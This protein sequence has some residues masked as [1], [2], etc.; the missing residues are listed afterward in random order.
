MEKN[1]NKNRDL[2]RIPVDNGSI[3]ISSSKQ[4]GIVLLRSR[5][6]FPLLDS[7]LPAL[8]GALFS[9]GLMFF[10][11]EIG[12]KTWRCV[13]S[14]SSF[15]PFSLEQLPDTIYQHF[16]VVLLEL[17]HNGAGSIIMY[18]LK[19]FPRLLYRPPLRIRIRR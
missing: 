18:S 10:K 4:L 15:F 8:G 17:H 6:S 3:F 12:K 9:R 19:P 11:I 16:N 5:A 2:G 7:I 14:S 13:S 1:R